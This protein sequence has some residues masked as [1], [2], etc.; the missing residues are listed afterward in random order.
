[1]TDLT[2]QE[3]W[4]PL[5]ASQ[6]NAANARHL[7]RRAAW[8]AQ[9]ADV[10]RA[11]ADG[12]DA[13]LN[14]LFPARPAP[15]PRPES[16]ERSRQDDMD[17]QE[18][19]R[20][21]TT[22][23]E[24]RALQKEQRESAQR[25]MQD[26]T[27]KWLQFAATP[28]FSAQEKWVL[29]LSDTYVVSFEK[30]RSPEHIYLHHAMLREFGLG[31]A[32]ALAKAVSRSPAMIR[33]LDLQQSKKTAPNENFARE[34][35]ELFLLGEGNYTE[36]DIKQ[37]ARA[38]TGYGLRNGRF[39]NNA[40]QHDGGPKTIF[41]HTGNYG[42]D[43]VIDLA[44]KLP[45][46]AA[47]APR[48]MARFYLTD[49]PLPQEHLDA[50]GAWWSGS[51]EGQGNLNLRALARRFFGSR[52]FYDPLHAGNYIK[53]PVQLY[54]GLM[55]DLQLDVAP[56]P[57]TVIAPLRAMG[58]A[59]FM[60]PNV[61][62]W[63]GGRSWINSA[64]LGARRQLV[65]NLFTPINETALNADE[66]AALAAARASGRDRLTFDRSR[67]S[68][69]DKMPADAIADT[70]LKIFLAGARTTAYRDE[71]L[72]YLKGDGKLA[73]RLQRVRD[74]AITLLQSPEYQLC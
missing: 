63:V 59:L 48:K 54:L 53:S 41:G 38:F 58:Q 4:L 64:T 8:S 17:F 24:K 42:G 25:A 44:F 14:R 36:Q 23:D 74:T 20:A 15:F 60:P 72:K 65:Q 40:L 29:F 13:T 16:V 2:P 39:F 35:F 11:V 62:G 6:W 5:P 67:L 34:L 10:E 32:P 66:Q 3:A 26:M 49:Q 52:L 7:L 56:F 50:L 70:F 27:L 55:Q 43:D 28:A 30:V 37:S 73:Q 9:P 51:A 33:Y 45:A 31:S 61:R 46:A 19:N 22:A 68:R 69:F 71:V 21:A 18:K 1:M 12:L 47:Y 57:R